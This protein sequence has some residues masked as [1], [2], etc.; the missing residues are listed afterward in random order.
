MSKNIT[1]QLSEFLEQ[2]LSQKAEK[3]DISLESLIIDVLEQYNSEE[4]AEN[5]PITPLIG[6][7]KME[8]NDLAENHDFYLSQA[9]Q[10]E[11]KGVE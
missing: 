1:L 6:T 9:L 10:Q 4:Q 2:Q 11:L 7:L 5:D 3:L 8:K